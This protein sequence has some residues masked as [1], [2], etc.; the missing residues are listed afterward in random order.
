[1]N[2]LFKQILII[3]YKISHVIQI[4]VKQ[5]KKKYFYIF[6]NWKFYIYLNILK[7]FRLQLFELR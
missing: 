4:Y 7:I 1:M 3:I 2:K 5:T 6:I